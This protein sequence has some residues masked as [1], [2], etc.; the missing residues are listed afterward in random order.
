MRYSQLL[1]PT[2]KEV[3]SDAEV[4]SHKLMIRAGYIRKV[5]SGTYT[6]LVLGLRSLRKAMQ[7]VREEMDAA[8]AQEILMPSLQPM[9]LWEKTGR[10]ADYGETMFDV[11]DRHGRHNTLSPTAE[12]VCT[13]HVAAEVSS[14]KQLPIN[15]Y[16]I[17]PKFRDEFRPRFGVLRSR[18]FIMKDAYSFDVD[19]AG[20]DV[21]YQKMYD[22]YCRIMTRCGLPYVPVEAESGPIGGSASHEFMIPCTAGED[23][24][25]HTEDY[26][27]A[28]NLERAEIDAP[29]PADRPTD[30]PAMEEVHT[31]DV[32]S[33]DAV[34]EFLGTRPEE[35]IKTLIYAAGE[36]TVVALVRGNHEINGNKLA[37]AAGAEAVELAGEGTIQK[38]SGADVGFAGPMGMAEK[39]AKLVVDPS[40]AALACGV[41]GANKTDTHV[42]NVVPGRDFPLEGDNVVVA[43]IRNAVEGDTHEGKAL[44]FTRG[45]E[46]GHVFKLGTKYSVALD[47]TF[48]D[49]HGAEKPCL[50]GCYG[51]GVNRL[52]AAAVETGFDENGCVMPISIAPCEVEVV[53]LST[54]DE[55][56]VAEAERIYAELQAAGVDVL[57]D[58]RDARP[59][60]KFKDADLIGIP[61]RLVVGQR[62]LKEG[63][64]EIKRR[65][66]EKPE[67]IPVGDAVAKAIEI[68]EE[69]KAK[70]AV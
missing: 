8:G 31:P 67:A 43:D 30:A 5:A 23:T 14:Y 42:R 36:E 59:G 4:E 32:G 46:A 20:L 39:V 18:E 69:L 48:L 1:I 64:V 52:V 50:M 16:Q 22:A 2:V 65:T 51:I 38:V 35:M 29:A 60:V 19:L 26:S 54:D 44:L 47:A 17:S 12:E 63:N 37:R 33:I 25:V 9:E 61:V 34:C 24:I 62:G 27:Y 57:L 10:R 15:L 68:V 70:L 7:I 6:Y 56:V 40:V 58:D 3:P 66:D 49:E 13:T 53:Q 21:S 11:P 28:A 55:Q 41:T 45:I